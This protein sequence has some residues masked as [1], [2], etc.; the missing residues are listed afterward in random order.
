MP[1]DEAVASR[2]VFVIVSESGGRAGGPKRF[3]S[4]LTNSK[5]ARDSIYSKFKVQKFLADFFTTYKPLSHFKPVLRKPKT[6]I[7][8]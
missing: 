2:A 1:L 5:T 4:Q 3:W 6:L 8:D 7:L